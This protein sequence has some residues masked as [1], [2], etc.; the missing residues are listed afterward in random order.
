RLHSREKDVLRP[1]HRR[2]AEHDAAAPPTIG[3][4]DDMVFSILEGRADVARATEVLLHA[5]RADVV[6]AGPRHT[7]PAETSEEGPEQHDGRAHPP[8]QLV[9]AVPADV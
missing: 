7:R 6:A 2:Q 4:G 5:P 1:G 3:P 8:A 9:G